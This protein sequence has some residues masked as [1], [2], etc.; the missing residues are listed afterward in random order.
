MSIIQ[1]FFARLSAQVKTPRP[2]WPKASDV[3]ISI[4]KLYDEP[5]CLGDHGFS[6]RSPR[7]PDQWFYVDWIAQRDG[8]E[9]RTGENNADERFLAF[10]YDGVG[11]EYWTSITEPE[12]RVYF[13]DHETGSLTPLEMTLR[14]FF[15]AEHCYN[16]PDAEEI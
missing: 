10:A 15:T 7:K 11:N 3:P 6:I 13:F 2:D 5:L 16:D 4:L 1:R 14:E 12:N 8:L 9:N